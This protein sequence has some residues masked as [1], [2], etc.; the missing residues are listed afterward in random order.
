[1]SLHQIRL[2]QILS[3]DDVIACVV[4]IIEITTVVYICAY[5]FSLRGV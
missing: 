3:A 2:V 1:M 4:G 5:L